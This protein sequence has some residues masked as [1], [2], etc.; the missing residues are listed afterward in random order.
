ML[1]L[2]QR[3]YTQTEQD[4]TN[5][6]KVETKDDNVYI[7]YIVFQ[8]SEVVKLKTATLGE[9]I[10]NRKDIST[11]KLISKD[12]IENKTYS[13]GDLHASRYLLAYNGYGLRKGNGYYQNM[14]IYFNQFGYGVTDKFS[15]GGGI[16]PLFL[17]F[18]GAS[19]PVWVIPKFSIPIK[20]D[21]INMGVGILAAKIAGEDAQSFGFAFSSVTF[22]S[23][24]KN[25]SLG[26]GYGYAG[27]SW[28]KL[29]TF[30]VSGK[31]RLGK[32]T[33]LMSE[34]YIISS[35]ED[36]RVILSMLGFKS[37]IRKVSI[38]YGLVV[39]I[40]SGMEQWFAI[41]WLGLTVPIGSN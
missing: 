10:I 15:I 20:K 18:G 19:S 28:A 29:P 13:Y 11:I 16:I 2:V 26:I 6:F 1:T 17:F 37:L 4:T 41:P 22:G 8:N 31:T 33:Y 14:W 21:K 5:V 39:P 35:S 36:D 23:R 32:R 12:R 24:D 27:S 40:Y 34:N 3:G 38:D 25:I 9:I 30:S 7:G